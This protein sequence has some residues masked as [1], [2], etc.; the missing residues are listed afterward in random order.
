MA[1]ADPRLAAVSSSFC[2]HLL[3]RLASPAPRQ[4]LAFSAHAARFSLRISLRL[5][6][7]KVARCC[8]D[9]DGRRAGGTPAARVALSV[10]DATPAFGR[11]FALTTDFVDARI[12]LDRLVLMERT[13]VFEHDVPRLFVLDHLKV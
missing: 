7:H 6:R 12:N 1:G 13:Q 11:V 8:C 10:L 9:S 3:G 5:H 2:P 4:F